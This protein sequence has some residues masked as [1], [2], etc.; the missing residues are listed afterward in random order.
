MNKAI[1]LF[2]Y[3]LSFSWLTA[4]DLELPSPEVFP[5]L[6]LFEDTSNVYVLK[7]GDACVLID[8][9]DGNVLP[10][11]NKIGVNRVEWVLLTHHHREQL[12][13]I[14]KVDRKVTNVAAPHGELELFE[15]P[16]HYRRWFPKLN[17]PY[18][19]YGASYSR[20][21]ARP[22]AID[23]AIKDG[24]TFE[25]RGYEINCTETPGHSPA[26]L[27]YTLKG[28][29]GSIGIFTGGHFH[30]GAKMS[31]WYDSEWDYGFGKGIDALLES[32]DK[33][34]GIS[35]DIAFPS[36]G[37][38][39]QKATHQLQRFKQKLSVFRKSYIRGYEP[40]KATPRQRDPISK[41]TEFS[42]INQIT[43]HLYKLNTETIGKNFTILIA[44]SGHALILDCGLFPEV[45]LHKLIKGMKEHLGLKQIDALWV[46]HMHGD[47]FLLGPALQK[48]YGAKTWTLD[49][50]ADVCENPRNYDYSA[51]VSSYGGGFDGMKI[52]KRFADGE[53]IEWEGYRIQVDWMPGQTKYHCAL[54]LEVDGM[55]VVSTGDNIFADSADCTQNGHEAVVARNN[56]I[57]EEGYLYGS[58]YLQELKPDLILG[59]HSYVMPNPE[60][61]IER[62]HNWSIDMIR[63][64]K[65]MLPD[66]DYEYLYDPNWVSAYPY[67]VDLATECT[68]KV[69]ITVR[70]FRSTPQ[71]HSIELVLPDGILAEPA[72]L[73]GLVG[74]ESSRTYSV[75]IQRS[76]SY[77]KSEQGIHIVPFDISLDGQHHGQLF[78][79]LIRTNM[80]ELVS[81][82]K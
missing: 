35:P 79:F 10:E 2:L 61:L 69:D 62:Y 12:Q 51:L 11:L 50:I 48:H 4:G 36:S 47:H 76:A 44:D 27:S 60:G 58:R 8:L 1:Y 15:N 73:K 24:D 63:L 23:R 31:S 39:I 52:D 46:S 20:P 14:E 53:S 77:R 22:V 32:T 81:N 67:R 56:A 33:L 29:D 25:W 18:T 82:E 57:I 55:K 7:E 66:T 34:I 78:D 42:M 6:Y 49:I 28:K 40:F 38:V 45:F 41:P 75:Q 70:N 74:P 13:G 21:L 71:S 65:D 26:S 16:T 59:S 17:D 37:P 68:Q 9:G 5:G 72:I 54:W 19:V 64:Y 43:P 30:E 3:I 80:P